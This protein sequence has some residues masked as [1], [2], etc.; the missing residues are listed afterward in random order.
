[1]LMSLYT[2]FRWVGPWHVALAT[3]VSVLILAF[4][5]SRSV[6]LTLRRG[7]IVWRD[8]FYTLADL[9]RNRV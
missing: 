9:R 7:G 2:A 6:Y 1:M 8:S 5:Y 3:P 4:I